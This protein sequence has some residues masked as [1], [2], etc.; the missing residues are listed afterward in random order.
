MGITS[1]SGACLAGSAGDST[2]AIAGFR[3]A[4]AEQKLEQKFLAVPEPRLAQQHLRILTAAPHIAGSPEDRKTAEYVA[5]KFREAGLQTRIDEYRVW[6]NLPR[7]FWLRPPLPPVSRCVAP[8]ANTS[9]A[10]PIRT[11][12]ESSCPSTPARPPAKRKP[13]SCTQTMPAR[14]ISPRSNRW[15][16][17]FAARSSSPAT[18][19][20]SA[21]SRRSPRSRTA[22][23][24][25]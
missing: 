22:P 8:P 2:P 15:A 21:A 16:L 18:G 11:I 13:N 3:N 5:R 19:R 14:R 25:S 9:M 7:K 23:P 1:Y 20:T 10:I 24:R 6:L 4:S 12:R 17:T